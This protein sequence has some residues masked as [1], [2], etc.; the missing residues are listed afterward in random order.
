MYVIIG[1]GETAL[2]LASRLEDYVIAD[3]DGEVVDK[4][5]EKGYNA[6]HVKFDDEKWL[7][8]LPISEATVILA[9]NDDVNL[10]VAGGI[11]G[12][13]KQVIAVSNSDEACTR[14]EELGISR[15]CR[16]DFAARVL[17]EV[18]ETKRRY[19]EI[20]VDYDLDGRA[21][22]DVDIGGACTVIS[23]LREGKFLRPHPELELKKGD[24][25][26]ILCGREVRY[27]KNPFEEVLVI[28]SDPEKA[29]IV[30]RE[31][32]FI[33]E[34]FGSQLLYLYRHG[35]NVACSIHGS[36]EFE[37]MGDEEVMSAI[38]SLPGKVDLLVTS[39]K[40][41]SLIEFA[42]RIPVLV[43]KGNTY[44]KI[45]AIVNTSDPDGILTFATSF[46]NL[47]GETKVLLLNPSQI[48]HSAKLTEAKLVVELSK[49]N[50]VI[51]A[52][53]EAKSDYDLIIISK[54]NDVGNIDDH[55][56][57]RIIFDTEGSVLVVG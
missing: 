33:A 56:L 10:E 3:E 36:F 6:V 30:L 19:I 26:G 38:S 2:S 40:S 7:E 23:V 17:S 53:K 11:V 22:K 42:D 43:A 20:E 57:R 48:S 35:G 44:R 28:I 55:L 31:A 12:R 25:I 21:L 4:L 15:V 34:K 50:P 8:E 1:S 5:L 9:S 16:S 47:V 51:D 37:P 41:S 18:V 29:A 32:E 14:Y 46:G 27:T 24:V 49:G 45:L 39:G 52:V 54:R 13:A